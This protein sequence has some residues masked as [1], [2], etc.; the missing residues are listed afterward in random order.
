MCIRDRAVVTT[1]FAFLANSF[2]ELPPL[3]TFG[4]TL[5]LGVISAFVVSTVSVGAVHVLVEK[6]A[7]EMQHRSL[8]M[9]R[10]ADLATRFQ[11]RNT[12]RVLLVVALITMGSVIVAI[13]E[14]D[15]SFELTDFLSEDG[16]EIIEVRNDMYDSYEAAAWKS[17][18][19][20]IE[21]A[22]GRDAP[23]SVWVL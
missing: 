14:L 21:P 5:A 2:S 22:S 8:Q 11:R 15:T 6:T 3:R 19:I 10:M 18:I 20:L 7:G 16:V 4:F 9:E 1:V 13:R 12:A 23:S 17:V